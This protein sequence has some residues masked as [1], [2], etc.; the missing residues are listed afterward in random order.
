MLRGA[1]WA[2]A[3]PL[4]LGLIGLAF[5]IHDLMAYQ[6]PR[7]LVRSHHYVTRPLLACFLFGTPL[8]AWIACSRLRKIQS[9]E[10]RR[11]WRSSAISGLIGSTLV[12]FGA[13]LIYSI[14]VA[15]FVDLTGGGYNQS[16]ADVGIVEVVLEML[17][18]NL[19]PWILIIL[20]LSLICATIFWRVTK[21]PEQLSP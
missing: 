3:L 20:P 21:F 9:V 2:C 7:F 17:A 11:R 13:V 14:C 8:A 18:F 16:Q 15:L 5:F 4:G 10:K 12:H 6:Q 19:I 1:V